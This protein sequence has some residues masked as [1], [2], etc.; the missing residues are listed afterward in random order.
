MVHLQS[1][2]IAGVESQG[3]N[4]TS[5]SVQISHSDSQRVIKQLTRPMS[6][7]VETLPMFIFTLELVTV[8]KISVATK[9]HSLH[10]YFTLVKH[11]QLPATLLV[12]SVLP[13][14]FCSC[15]SFSISFKEYQ[16]CCRLK[17]LSLF[18]ML[19]LNSIVR[20][21]IFMLGLNSLFSFPT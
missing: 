13:F 10:Y 3:L 8:K 2:C 12:P 15:S 6:R 20:K 16:D 14:S 21:G 17:R 9:A 5:L 1:P 4:M 7:M 11:L 19:I 18:L